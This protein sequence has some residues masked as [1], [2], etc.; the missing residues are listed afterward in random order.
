MSIKMMREYANKMGL[1]LNLDKTE[2]ISFGKQ[3]LPDL[4]VD[5]IVVKESEQVKSQI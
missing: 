4:R 2:V 3:K 1:A 5:N